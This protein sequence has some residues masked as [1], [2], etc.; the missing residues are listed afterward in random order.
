MK[1]APSVKSLCEEVWAANIKLHALGLAPF[2]FGNVSG[3]DRA[4]GWFA[5]KPSGMPYDQMRAQ[6][7]VV[8]DFEG[9]IVAG[10]RQ[11]S[12]DTPTHAALY[13]ALAAIGGIAHTHS[14]YA[15]GFA[16]ARRAIPI[17]GTTHAD[18]FPGDIPCTPPMTA[19]AIRTAYE[20]NTGLHIVRTL[21]RLGAPQPPMVLVAAHGPFT[22]GST[23]D[24]AVYESA[25]CEEIARMAYLALQLNPRVT[26]PAQALIRKHYFRK[27]GHSATYGQQTLAGAATRQD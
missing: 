27:H 25:M 20:K 8:V 7:M 5:I 16:Q 6:D 22:W 18:H 13:R 1:P 23:A 3:C 21:A 10:A 12:S 4:R 14:P 9:Q 2:T 15:V 24:A 17:L 26:R 11:P 19:A